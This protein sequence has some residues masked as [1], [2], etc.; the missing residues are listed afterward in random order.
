M[1]SKILRFLWMKRV[2]NGTLDLTENHWQVFYLKKKEL[3]V[4]VVFRLISDVLSS[5]HSITGR[6]WFPDFQVQS[7][8]MTPARLGQTQS[9]AC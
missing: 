5:P 3:S 8:R 1:S 7:L 4:I 6:L 9:D 2:L